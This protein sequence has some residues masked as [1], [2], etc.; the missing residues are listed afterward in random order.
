MRAR[1][2]LGATKTETS[3]DKNS[4]FLPYEPSEKLQAGAGIRND[5]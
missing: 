2:R 5:S 4:S 1:P 3:E